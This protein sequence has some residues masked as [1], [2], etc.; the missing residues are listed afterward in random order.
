[1]RSFIA[2]LLLSVFTL[3]G[4]A[5]HTTEPNTTP[6]PIASVSPA[7]IAVARAAGR[8]GLDLALSNAGVSADDRAAIL[9]EIH[10]IVEQAINGRDIRSIVTDPATWTPLRA[11]LVPRLAAV[12]AQ[13]RIQG[14]QVYTQESAEAF[15]GQ[16][17]DAFV[18]VAG[19]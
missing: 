16:L 7:V 9:G 19:R 2:V 12:L 4:C 8:V 17:L 6:D 11:A 1:M 18:S 3:T 14:V 10:V 5:G 13:V 15:I